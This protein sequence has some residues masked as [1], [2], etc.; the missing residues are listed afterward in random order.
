M[1]RWGEHVMPHGN[2]RCMVDLDASDWQKKT[3]LCNH[4]FMIYGGMWLD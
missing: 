3:C 2:V 4:I 1:E